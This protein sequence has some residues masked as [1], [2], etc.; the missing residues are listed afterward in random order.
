[1]LASV[2]VKVGKVTASTLELVPLSGSPSCPGSLL[3]GVQLLKMY[4]DFQG[5]KKVIES[6]LYVFRILCN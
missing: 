3:G 6:I 4:R 1:M 2:T 5:E